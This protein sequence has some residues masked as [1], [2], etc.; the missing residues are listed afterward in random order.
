MEG[1]ISSASHDL[2]SNEVLKLLGL[3]LRD[4]N[5]KVESGKKGKDKIYLDVL[6]DGSGKALMSSTR[7]HSMTR[8]VSCLRLRQGGPSITTN[9]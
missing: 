4:E 9:F 5:F 2:S 3:P 8:R 6:F 1:A 7:M